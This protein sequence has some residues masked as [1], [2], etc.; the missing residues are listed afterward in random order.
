M[1]DDLR[2]TVRHPRPGL[3][4]AAVTGALDLH[5]APILR[6]HVLDL[7]RQGRPHLILDLDQVGFCDSTGLSV[8]IGVWHAAQEA[9]GSLALAH[10]PDRMMRM[11]TLT[12]VD[13]LLPLHPTTADAVSAR[14]T[15]DAG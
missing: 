4:V 2:L 9:G 15:A 10:V 5:A 3:A 6:A 8:I 14:P 7:I 13:T 1:S 12:G 11:L